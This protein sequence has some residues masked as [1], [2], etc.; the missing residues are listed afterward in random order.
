[1]IQHL[2]RKHVGVDEDEGSSA[3]AQAATI[4]F[5]SSFSRSG[6]V[7]AVAHSPAEGL[8]SC[9]SPNDA[10]PFCLVPYLEALCP[11]STSTPRTS[12][13]QVAS[14]TQSITDTGPEGQTW[15]II[16][17]VT[18]SFSLED[19]LQVL[20]ECESFMTSKLQKH[21]NTLTALLN[22]R[23]EEMIKQIQKVY[24]VERT[25]ITKKMEKVK[26]LQKSH[27]PLTEAAEEARNTTNLPTLV[28]CISQVEPPPAALCS[29]PI[30]SF[31]PLLRLI[32]IIEE[33]FKLL[34]LQF[35]CGSP[36][37]G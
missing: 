3:A 21:V 30:R 24:N 19:P 36:S 22:S 11:G 31:C 13:T 12:S 26:L 37:P 25:L 20:A 1:M 17:R 29:Y 27:I 14:V 9:G 28:G 32:F 5:I 4:S 35:V 18:S 6:N 23:F 2:K 16:H 33:E 7:S 10:D 34:D 8:C 15:T